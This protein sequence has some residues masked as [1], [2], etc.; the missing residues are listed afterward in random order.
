MAKLFGENY[1]AAGA[2]IEIGAWR[3][4]GR[5]FKGATVRSK[6]PGEITRAAGR[7]RARVLSRYEVGDGPDRWVPPVGVLGARVRSVSGHSGGERRAA[8]WLLQR[9]P[10]TGPRG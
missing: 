3:G 10:G 5:V 9:G 7:I 2:K 8:R 4:S 1:A 6:V